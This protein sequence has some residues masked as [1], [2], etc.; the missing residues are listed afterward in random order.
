MLA[1]HRRGDPVGRGGVLEPPPALVA[2][3]LLVDLGVVA[4]QPAQHL[5]APPVGAHVAAGRA[6]LADAG[7]GHQ[8]ER[9][10][11]EPVLRAGQRADRADLY[12]VAGEVGLERVAGEDVDLLG[13]GAVHQVDERVAGDLLGEPGAALAQDAALAVEQH[14]RRDADRLLVGAL[15][16]VEPGVRAAA[17]H[18]LVLQ[19]ALPALVAH[20]AIERVV[21]QEKL[22]DPLLRLLRH[23]G[24]ELGPHDHA[25]G[26][27]LGTGGDRLALALHLH[28]ALPAGTG[29]GQQRVVAEARDRDAEPLGDPDH[30]LTLGRLYL[31]TVDGQRYLVAALGYVGH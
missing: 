12:G 25:V 7:R 30:Q 20:R 31:D 3:P 4:G 6:V 23:V 14:L 29:R 21:D 15:D 18:R 5:A 19:R 24:R 26:D 9:A 1:D 17:G 13:G 22:H 2:V 28:Q 16:V 27:G 11:A 8:V 10:G